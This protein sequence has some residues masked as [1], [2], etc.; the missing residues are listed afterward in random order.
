[1]T[2]GILSTRKI[3]HDILD[4]AEKP[5]NKANAATTAVVRIEQL[6]PFPE[7]QLQAALKAYPKAKSIVWAQEEPRNM[8]AATFI[9]PKIEKLVGTLHAGKAQLD[10]VGRSERASPAVGLEKQHL[11]EQEKLINAAWNLR[12]SLEV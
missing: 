6:H 5:E 7:Q 10:Y 2:R 11:K 12:E 4:G 9:M 3:A 1:V 8:G